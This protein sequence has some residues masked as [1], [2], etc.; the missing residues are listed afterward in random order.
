MVPTFAFSDNIAGR[1]PHRANL[2]HLFVINWL[3]ISTLG[4]G[5]GDLIYI[6]W[7]AIYFTVQMYIMHMAG[8]FVFLCIYCK[9]TVKADNPFSILYLE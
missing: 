9:F 4:Q 1:P 7:H 8:Q 6:L 2:P 5:P 3:L